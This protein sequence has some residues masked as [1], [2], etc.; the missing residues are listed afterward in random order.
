[1]RFLALFL[2][3]LPLF[4]QPKVDILWD[5]YG[6]AHV[7]AQNPEGLFFG[8][9]YASMQSHGDLILKLYGESRGRAAEYWGP[10]E[11]DDNIKQDRWVRVNGVPERGEHGTT[12]RPPI[13]VI[14]SCMGGRH[15]H[16]FA[17]ASRCIEPEEH[18]V[19]YR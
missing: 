7:Y 16:L 5:H 13:Q 14:F 2:C 9:G 12:N 1:M 4:A 11:K 10:G 15:E 18:N 19:S 17:E 8:Y 3:S 6:V